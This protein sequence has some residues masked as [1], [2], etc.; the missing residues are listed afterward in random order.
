MKVLVSKTIFFNTI[1]S[2]IVLVPIFL[3]IIILI[4]GLNISNSRKMPKNIILN[5]IVKETRELY[6]RLNLRNLI[7]FDSDCF[8]ISRTLIYQPKKNAT[9]VQ[10]N[11]EF[12]KEVKFGKYRNRID[13][14]G[15]SSRYD[16]IVLGDSQAMGWGVSDEE[17][18][19]NTLQ[20]NGKKTLNL[21][22][23]S[24]GTAKE[25][26]TLKRW[27]EENPSL[28]SDVEFI[29]LQY[30]PG[31]INENLEYLKNK[32]MVINPTNFDAVWKDWLK[33]E[34]ARKNYS[35]LSY[36]SYP[37]L[38]IY[39]YIIKNFYSRKI[40]SL[41][42]QNWGYFDGIT[43]GSMIKVRSN[44]NHG[45]PLI[46]LLKIY[47]NL[48]ENKKIIIFVTDSYGINVDSVKKNL[49]ME[50]SKSEFKYLKDTV[51]SSLD[52]DEI[53]KFYYVIDDHMNPIGHLEMGN[54]ISSII[55]KL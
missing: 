17:I 55:K 40:R 29:V 31:D 27:A 3:P 14:Y 13:S 54:I 18:F 46:D 47:K 24:Y 7:Q 9:C 25:L 34:F 12:K 52:G 1:F 2:L 42:G 8:E 11:F 21:S 39:P 19:T 5:S 43:D 51:F 28:Y 48:L 50:F 33:N 10:D 20:A 22:V 37:D 16:V 30:E 15:E 6:F 35:H 23:S 32:N 4:S 38:I 53:S 26:F 45:R 44:R 41:F 36:K 49:S